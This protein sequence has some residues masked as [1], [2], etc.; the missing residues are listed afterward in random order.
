M[1][2]KTK[3]LLLII[4]TLVSILIISTYYGHKTI[5]R[6]HEQTLKEDA[7]KIARQI[8]SYIPPDGK[9]ADPAELDAHLDEF[10]FLSSHVVRVDAYVFRDAKLSPVVS[11]SRFPVDL[12]KLSQHE[13][14]RVSF[15]ELL[16]DMELEDGS[17]FVNFAAPLRAG[18]KVFGIAVFKVSHEEFIRTM[19]RNRRTLLL[20][21]A[22]SL[23][24]V[25]GVLFISMDW[26]V[27]RPIQNLL[28]A[29]SCVKKG[30]LAVTVAPEADDEIGKLTEHFNEMLSTIKK[31][32]DEKET[33]LAQI[34]RHNDELQQNIDR[35][36]EELRMRN[37]ALR[38]ANQSI[39]EIQKKLG[40][41]R[42]LAAVGQLAAT[43]AHEFGTPLHSVSGHLQLLMEEPGLSPE[44]TRRITIM[45]S[46]VERITR[47]IQ[48]LLDTT[49][50]PD[51]HDHLDINRVMEDILLL[52][53]PEITSRQIEV[54]K[55]FKKGL[56]P[57]YAS[58][59]RMQEVFLNIVDNAIDASHDGGRIS[60]STSL[61]KEAHKGAPKRMPPSGMWVKVTVRDNGR[62]IPEELKEHI[63]TPYYTTKAYGQGTGLGLPICKEIVE[64]CQGQITVESRVDE[65]SVFTVYLPAEHRKGA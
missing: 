64:N 60:I 50:P 14:E 45:Q 61:A 46:Q 33:L 16:M 36:T 63:F 2:I 38:A 20:I 53:M 54:S 6:D 12:K 55:D 9:I 47:S 51:I 48:N 8:E 32:D 4:S 56:P 41:S 25:A 29:I 22:V 28:A 18:G 26:L 15:G 65:G 39:Y 57:V 34:N 52:V 44:T 40:H 1:R 11:K 17:N 27:N 7:S 19:A 58:S 49:R 23:L 43:V 13:L 31:S 42:R 21:A 62:G 59:S 24:G 3:I 30:D 10:L 37:E 5:E 35:A